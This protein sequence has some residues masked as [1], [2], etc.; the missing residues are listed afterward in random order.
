VDIVGAIRSAPLVD[1]ALLAGF[2]GAFLLGA[3]QGTI[4][5]I[6]GTVSIVFAFLVAANLRAPVG[7]YLA[8]QWKDLPPE[9]D[10]FFA[11]GIMFVV[12][13]VGFSVLIQ[14]F[15][16]HTELSAA[17]PLLDDV[18]GGMMGLLQAVILL[19]AAVIILGSYDM[20]AT[21]VPGEADQVRWIH[22]LLMH[23]SHIAGA[24]RDSVAPVV[25]HLLA[26]ILPSELVVMFP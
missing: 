1:L 15:Y 26:F 18:A 19:I 4:R 6:L 3:I 22:D 21:P 5:R 23:Q 7:D 13:T 16:K 24:F 10:R 12:L 20:P 25:V 11:F 17:H 8:G 9:Y 2:F 14:G